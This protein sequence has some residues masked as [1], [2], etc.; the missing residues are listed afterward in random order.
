ME[1]T[2]QH[3]GNVW[4][5]AAEASVDQRVVFL[6][7]VGLLSGAGLLIAAVGA[8]VSMLAIV[9]V[10]ALASGWVPLIV[11]L[12][13]VMGAQFIGSSM[14][15]SQDRVTQ[16]GGFV[17]GSGLMG[18]AM[19]YLLLTAAVL[20]ADL[21]GNAFLF[22]G[23]AGGL[24]GLTVVGMVAYLL[25][26]PRNLSMIGSA[27]GVMALPMLGLMVVSWFFNPGGLFGILISVG[28]VAFSA[29]GLLYSLNQVMHRMSTEM[30]VPAAYQITLGVLVL[31]W[32]VL[33]LLMRL[34]RR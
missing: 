4:T 27:L 16:Y 6:R 24:V 8:V 31:F 20:S 9:A 19:G 21:Y 15:A 1:R 12:G 33:V 25:S 18:V 11:M 32:N 28:F 26:G 17:F 23:Q 22:I 34:Q 3:R 10:P 29:G 2:W 7:K 14:V 30:V 5:P 13:G